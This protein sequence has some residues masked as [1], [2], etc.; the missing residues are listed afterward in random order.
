VLAKPLRRQKYQAPVCKHFSSSAIIS[1]FCDCGRE[2][3]KVKWSLGGLSFCLHSIFCPWISFRL[4]QFGD[5]KFEMSKWP[6]P[7]TGSYGFIGGSLFR[8]YLPIFLLL[9]LISLPLGTGSLSN[10]WHLNFLVVPTPCLHCPPLLHS[11]THSPG[12]QDF[13]AV[14]SNI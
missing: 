8:F 14:S 7:S 2:D 10:P 4:G 3:P 12:P 11:S 13:S 9:Q 6:L 5:K 1:G